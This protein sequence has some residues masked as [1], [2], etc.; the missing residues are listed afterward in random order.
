MFDYQVPEASDFD[1]EVTLRSLDYDD[2]ATCSCHWRSNH[3]WDGME[4]AE[5][6]WKRHESGEHVYITNPPGHQGCHCEL[7]ACEKAVNGCC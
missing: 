2:W 7:P 1:H 6:E 4:L 5:A 3:Y